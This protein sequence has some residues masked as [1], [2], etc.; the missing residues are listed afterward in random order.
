MYALYLYQAMKDGYSFAPLPCQWLLK[1]QLAICHQ[2]TWHEAGFMFLTDCL[3]CFSAKADTCHTRGIVPFQYKRGCL[4]VMGVAIDLPI[5]HIDSILCQLACLQPA[6]SRVVSDRFFFLRR[7]LAAACQLGSPHLF[8]SDSLD[9]WFLLIWN[10]TI[11]YCHPHELS[12][13]SLLRVGTSSS[14][15]GRNHPAYTG[16]L[17]LKAVFNVLQFIVPILLFHVENCSKD[18]KR[19]LSE[20]PGL[21]FWK[22]S[23][24]KNTLWSNT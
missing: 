10:N 11:L 4:Q 3:S 22:R 8:A 17:P 14:P 15:W 21:S 23:Q 12:T 13:G 24:C 6:V 2:I 20:D 16:K 1:H 19:D 9:V 5:H 7:V 18:F